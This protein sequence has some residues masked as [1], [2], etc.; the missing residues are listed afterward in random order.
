MFV[1][2]LA[3]E[4]GL[5]AMAGVLPSKFKGTFLGLIDSYKKQMLLALK[6]GGGGVY[7]SYHGVECGVDPDS[8]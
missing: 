1:S 6:V 5:R 4:G 2:P 7:Y 8:L 3:G